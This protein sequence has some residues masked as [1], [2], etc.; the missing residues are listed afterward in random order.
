MV[1]IFST[2]YVTRTGSLGSRVTLLVLMGAVVRFGEKMNAYGADHWE[3]FATQNYFD[4]NGIFFT[5]VVSAPLL[6]ITF[7]MLVSYLRE[8]MGL[9]VQVKK[10]E[11][12]HKKQNAAVKSK[13]KK[14]KKKKSGKEE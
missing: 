9:L 4:K 11:M 7:I 2:I 8:A 14:N 6:L 10:Q 5:I 13:N 3:A 1:M 12:K